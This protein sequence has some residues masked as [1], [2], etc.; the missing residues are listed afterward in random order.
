MNEA[1]SNKNSHHVSLKISKDVVLI[2]PRVLVALPF[3]SAAP[4]TETGLI[5]EASAHNL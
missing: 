1:Q 3:Y 4:S 2:A 5:Y